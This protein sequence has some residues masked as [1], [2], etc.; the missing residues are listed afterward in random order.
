MNTAELKGLHDLRPTTPEG[1]VAK[2]DALA[3]LERLKSPEDFRKALI[4]IGLYNEDGTRNPYF[5]PDAE[6]GESGD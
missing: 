2:K 3:Y 1:R 4:A 5:Y 6:K